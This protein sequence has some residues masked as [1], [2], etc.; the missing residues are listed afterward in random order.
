ME[1]GIRE[2]LNEIKNGDSTL[3]TSI[4]EEL[5]IGMHNLK[6]GKSTNLN[7]K[8]FVSDKFI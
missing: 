7:L 8:A 4:F 5:N 2:P 1:K 3:Q 6:C